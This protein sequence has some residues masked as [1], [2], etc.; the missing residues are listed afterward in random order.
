MGA[1]K[2]STL[3]DFAN[4]KPL[5]LEAIWGETLRR[6]AAAGTSMPR[7]EE[8]YASLQALDVQ[9]REREKVSSS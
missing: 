7:L 9:N 5:E 4:G 2:P 3:I 1:Y 6:A 8:L